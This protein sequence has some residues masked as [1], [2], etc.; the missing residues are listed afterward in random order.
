MNEQDFKKEFEPIKDILDKQGIIVNADDYDGVVVKKLEPNNTRGSGEQTHIEF[1]GDQMEM[2]PYLASY[3]YFNEDGEDFKSFYT[4]KMPISLDKLNL[5]YLLENHQKYD[6][7]YLEGNRVNTFENMVSFLNELLHSDD[8]KDEKIDSYSTLLRGLKSGGEH[9]EI[10]QTQTSDKKFEAFRWLLPIYSYIII[11]KLRKKVEYE[12]YGILPDDAEE[13]SDL[14][15]KFYYY[16]T[17]QGVKTLV[18]LENFE[19]PHSGDDTDD[20]NEEFIDDFKYNRLSGGK[21]R[22][23]YGVPGCG[24]SWTIKNEICKDVNEFFIERVV[25]HPDYTYSDFVGQILPKFQKM[26]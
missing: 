7:S 22:L 21:N 15:L 26:V 25:F 9:T 1:T 19:I 8:F 13:I 6:R 4:F 16:H 11:L 5:Q 12:V 10:S 20:S 2:F 3:K 24:K 14:H 23:L 18:P 17:K